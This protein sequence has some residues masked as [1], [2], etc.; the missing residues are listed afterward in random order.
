L[1]KQAADRHALRPVETLDLASL[2]ARCR[3]GDELAWEGFVRRFQGRVF[4]LACTYVTD[5]EGAADLA[6][7]IFIRLFETRARWPRHG[8]FMPWMFQVARN[9]AIDFLRRRKVRRPA[10]RVLV[11]DVPELADPGE[12]PEARAIGKSR[13]ER[14][15]AAL[16]RVSALSREILLL[17]DVQGLSVQEAAAVL[18]VPAG[19]V[20]SRSNRAR[21]ELADVMLRSERKRSG[22]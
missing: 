12:G 5:R 21:V 13:R 18:G 8:E 1:E 19:T 11:D 3:A 17:R 22:S 9:L 4:G 15:R 14:L 16:G 20:K 7:E 2:I 10:V 6:Q